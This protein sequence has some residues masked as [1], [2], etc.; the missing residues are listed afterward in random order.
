MPVNLSLNSSTAPEHLGSRYGPPP[1]AADPRGGDCKGGGGPALALVKAESQ[2]SYSGGG[3]QEEAREQIRMLYEQSHYDL[4]LTGYLKVE[5]RSTPDSTYEDS[6]D[7]EVSFGL[8][9]DFVT[10]QSGMIC[11]SVHFLCD[12]SETFLF[13]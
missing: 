11:C 4:P 7:G 13:L 3:Y 9:G 8:K 2:T 1:L 5:K 12:S 10:Y 6:M